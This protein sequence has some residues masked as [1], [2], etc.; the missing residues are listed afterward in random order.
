MKLIKDLQHN[1]VMIEVLTAVTKETVEFLFPR[2]NIYHW[3][4]LNHSFT[5]Q[6]SQSRDMLYLTMENGYEGED[7]YGIKPLKKSPRLPT[8][9]GVMFHAE[10][11][12]RNMMIMEKARVLGIPTLQSQF[13]TTKTEIQNGFDILSEEIRKIKVRAEDNYI[14]I[15]EDATLF[16]TIPDDEWDELVYKY[17]GLEDRKTMI[18]LGEMYNMLVLMN[19][20]IEGN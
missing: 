5:Y 3:Y 19:K 20:L 8:R 14:D 15:E 18:E 6:Y 4:P 13:K 7:L 2:R 1:Q 17:I 16:Q 9:N 12:H 11:F 10:V